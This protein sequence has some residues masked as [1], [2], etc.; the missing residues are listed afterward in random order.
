MKTP[1]EYFQKRRAVLA[2]M[3]GKE[4]IIAPLLAEAFAL[5]V[6]VPSVMDTD[7]FGTFTRDIKRPADQRATARL[8][9]LKAMEITGADLGIASEGSFGVHPSMPFA[10]SNTEIVILIDRIHDLEILGGY[11]SL[12][13]HMHHATVTSV[14]EAIAFATSHDFPRHGLILR[15]SERSVRGMQK[16]IASIT[17][18]EKEVS[19][20]L[21]WSW[22]K[23][24]FLETDMRADRNPTRCINIEKAAADLICKMNCLCPTCG[25]PGFD[26]GEI[27]KGLPCRH[28]NLPTGN[29]L[30]HL[31]RCK[32]CGYEKEKVFPYGKEHADPGQCQFCNP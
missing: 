14:A 17:E 32:K 9:A 7:R 19:T 28:C 20:M 30:S 21:R 1:R 29:V 25:I 3:H 24:V 18:L 2:T 27:R 23:S 8:K 13:T 12:H 4:K 15:R 10:P 11:L 5:D 22:R 16:D 31:Y 26:Y 6:F